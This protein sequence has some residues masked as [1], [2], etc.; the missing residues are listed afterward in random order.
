MS[1][2]KVMDHSA[3]IQKTKGMSEEELHYTMKDCREAMA[4][5]PSG[6]NDGYYADEINYCGMEL[7]R[8]KM[9]L[10]RGN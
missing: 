2:K 7:H 6:I 10:I 5:N 4:A 3:Y 9:I 1:V 8:R